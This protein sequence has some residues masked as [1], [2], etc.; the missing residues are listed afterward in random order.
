MGR[1]WS[2]MQRMMSEQPRLVVCIFAAFVG[3]AGLFS[4]PPLDRDEA[5]FAQASAQ[6]LETGDFVTIRF[7]DEERNKKPA[8]IHWLQSAA[9]AALSSSD[10]RNIWAYRIPSFLAM[11]G[12]SFFVFLI[13]KTLFNAKTGLIAG[14]L[15]ASAPI[16]A[17]EATIAKTD[18]VLLLTICIAQ[19]ALAKSLVEKNAPLGRAII[20]WLALAASILIKGP[21][22]LL[23]CGLTLVT[24]CIHQS[25]LK[26][27]LMM[28]PLLGIV[29]IMVTV[30]P[31]VIAINTATEG[32]F[33]ADAIGGDLLGKVGTAQERHA[34]PPGYHLLLLPI[35]FWPAAGFLPRTVMNAF[36]NRRQ[37]AW[38]F[39]IA[40]ALPAW[41]IFELTST[42]LPHYTLP[43]YP[44]V[45]IAIAAAIK[46]ALDTRSPQQR[47]RADLFGILLYGLISVSVIMAVPWLAPTYHGSLPLA[48]TTSIVTAIGAAGCIFLLI[49]RA[50]YKAALTAI[51][52]SG[53]FSWLIMQA[54]LPSFEDFRT[55]PL[56]ADLVKENKAH[57][58]DH[59]APG[60]FIAGYTEPSLVFFLGSS[61]KIGT[62]EAAATYLIDTP[63]AAALIENKE[64][65]AFLA[66]LQENRGNVSKITTVKGINYSK[67]KPVSIDVYVHHN[68]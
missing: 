68:E 31:W 64:L 29:L 1:L 39:L 62:G 30:S 33:F 37:A 11:I 22:G 9:V 18:A 5:R 15:F 53:A 54:V 28:R 58:L 3:L 56:L 14:L 27:L 2:T 60:T 7:L 48:L 44:A 43:L 24:L 26:P 16:A 35:L 6:M 10:A 45:A 63:G 47:T 46:M 32:R 59:G 52:C 8:G 36:H 21:I 38:Q 65:T 17:A 19:W 12:V 50:F 20:F 57:E 4:L 41:V 40:W 25:T 42:K 66:T 13:G 34:G 61:T 49:K 23:V 67:G 55:S 51:F